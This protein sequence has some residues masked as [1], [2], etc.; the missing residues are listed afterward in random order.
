MVLDGISTNPM[1]KRVSSQQVFQAV[2]SVKSVVD[3]FWLN[4]P[5]AGKYCPT[6]GE[7]QPQVAKELRQM[8]G[9]S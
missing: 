5:Q 2:Q 8:L 4:I 3:G 6:C 1:G 9:A 7:A